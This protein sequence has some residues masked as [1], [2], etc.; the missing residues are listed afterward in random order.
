[1]VSITHNLLHKSQPSYLTQ[2]YLYQ[3]HWQNAIIR[4][5]LSFSLFRHSHPSSN[6]PIA[7]SET[8]CA[9]LELSSHQ[10]QVFLST[11]SYTILSNISSIQHTVSFTQSL[12]LPPQNQPLLSFIPLLNSP[13]SSPIYGFQQ[14]S[15][16]PL[17]HVCAPEN[18]PTPLVLWGLHKAFIYLLTLAN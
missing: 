14:V 9:S 10:S 13:P 3:T 12:P 16:A 6:S 4:S 8:L 2:A 1:M 18:T 7:L 17:I 15:S 11:N 5:P